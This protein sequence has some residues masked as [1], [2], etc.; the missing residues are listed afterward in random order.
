MIEIYFDLAVANLYIKK[1][2][3]TPLIIDEQIK[4]YIGLEHIL[5]YF[6]TLKYIYSTGYNFTQHLT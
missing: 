3:C 4:N 1:L 2:L 5:L 6:I